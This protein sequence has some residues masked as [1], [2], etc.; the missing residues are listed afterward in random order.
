VLNE[1][2][3]QANVEVVNPGQARLNETEKLIL[4]SEV[5]SKFP[6]AKVHSHM[7]EE[8]NAAIFYLQVFENE[9]WGPLSDFHLKLD[10]YYT[11]ERE[12]FYNKSET[13]KRLIK[14]Y[15][16]ILDELAN[17]EI[18]NNYSEKLKILKNKQERVILIEGVKFINEIDNFIELL[19]VDF[20]KQQNSILNPN[21]NIHFSDIE[22]KRFLEGRLVIDALHFIA[23]FCAEFRDII[24]IPEEILKFE[25]SKGR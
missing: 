25:N 8:I 20:G 15:I 10:F 13:V 11:H 18:A 16:D 22:G 23:K 17:I 4:Q 6:I 2:E 1:N 24:K 14:Q 7:N 19:L 3:P 9:L 5:L 21:D 12:K